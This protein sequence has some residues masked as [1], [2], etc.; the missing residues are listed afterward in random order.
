MLKTC[1]NRVKTD[2]N[3]VKTNH[4]R[5]KTDQIAVK[6]DRILSKTWI[7]NQNFLEF[8]KINKNVSKKML[9]LS[10]L[11]DKPQTKDPL[12]PNSLTTSRPQKN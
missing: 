4:Y 3:R 12:T 11:S 9:N 6:S 1:L 5:L 2:Q 10:K 8:F 7:N